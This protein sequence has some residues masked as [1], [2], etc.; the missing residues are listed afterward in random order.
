MRANRVGHRTFILAGTAVGV[1]VVFLT[2][3]IAVFHDR[4]SF[5]VHYEVIKNAYGEYELAEVKHTHGQTLI[6]PEK[7]PDGE[8]ITVLRPFWKDPSPAPITT[9][10]IPDSYEQIREGADS[11]L[12]NLQAVRIGAGV[13][14]ISGGLFTDSDQVVSLEVSEENPYYYSEGNCVID[15][16]S[17]T[18]V[19]GCRASIIPVT[20]EQLGEAAFANVRGLREIEIPDSVRRIK[21]SCFWGCEN[22]RTVVIP[23]SVTE[24]GQYA[25][26][27]CKQ[28]TVCCRSAE[29]PLHW[30]TDWCD[31]DAT[32]IWNDPD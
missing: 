8:T 26:M 10:I 4:I 13:K 3:L 17:Q 31:P 24:I 27:N 21:A 7:T 5:R 9:L 32:V 28:L 15:R 29:R 11:G 14:Q 25:F 23:Q 6:L 16:K 22:L 12:T 2:V 1:L 18:V 20:V 30:D 19:L